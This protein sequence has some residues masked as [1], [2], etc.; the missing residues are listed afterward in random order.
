MNPDRTLED[1]IEAL[2]AAGIDYMVTGSV[3]GSYHGV[4]RS[5]RD[6][7]LVVDGTET[8]FLSFAEA[9]SRKDFYVSEDAVRE[10]V[11]S[12]GQFNVIDRRTAWKVDLIVRKDR[13]FSRI[14]FA[15]RKEEEF[16]G[17]PLWIATPED[18]V[19]AKLEWAKLTDSERQLEDVAGILQTQGESLDIAYIERWVTTLCLK[20]QWQAVRGR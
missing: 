16:S 19:L 7:D 18:V 2:G 6:I 5:T 1:V 17:S 12:R 13:E 9:I 10:A 15:R 20:E 14:E 11:K 3:A 4:P 8:A